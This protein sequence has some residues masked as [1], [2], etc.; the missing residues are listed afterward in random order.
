MNAVNAY[1]ERT[2]A[3]VLAEGIETDAHVS[4]ARSLGATLGQGWHF[5]RPSAAPVV[6]VAQPGG[7]GLRLP[8][9]TGRGELA[10]SVSP[11][12]CLPSDTVLMRAP[13]R[14]LVELSKQ[15][16]REAMRLGPTCVVAAT[17]QYREHFTA[18]TALRYRD[19]V[20]R[21]GFVCAIGR[22]L[23]VEPVPG[24]RGPSLGQD[25]P[26]LGEWDV[27]VLSPHFSTA[28]LARDLGDPGPDMDRTFEYALTYRR[29]TVTA[30]AHQLLLR[31][32]PRPQVTP[33]E[34]RPRRVGD[35]APDLPAGPAGGLAPLMVPTAPRAGFGWGE[36]LALLPELDLAGEALTKRALH[37]AR[38]GVT[39][40]DMTKPDEPL[41]FV[42][43]AFERLAGFSAVELLGRNCRLLQ[44]PDTD[45][46]AI[47]RIRSAVTDGRESREL[48]LNYRGPTREPW[49]NEVHLSPVTD[50]TGRVVQYIG[51]QS[52]VTARVEAE[53]ELVRERN[54]GRAY[55][56]QIEQ[57]AYTDPLTGLMNRRRFEDR[58]ELALLTA[59]M[60]E[61]A[62]ALLFMDLDDFKS[63]NDSHGHAAGDQLLQATARRLQARVRGADLL[64]RLGGDEFL[65]ALTGLHP[66][67]ATRQAQ[68][69][70][71]QLA[72]AV[73]VPVE[74]DTGQVQVTASTGIATSAGDAEEVG[75]LLHLADMRM[76]DL[77]HPALRE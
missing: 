14:L 10:E 73:S 26:V 50:Q 33:A 29:D 64:A 37:A 7:R 59:R 40:A 28:L 18:S 44:G 58:F 56:E 74:L 68:R 36:K 71:D 60:N 24:L 6:P 8:S 34:L 30:A 25:D 1:A 46:A 11:F 53:R 54:R 39:I 55:L 66:R 41:I 48:V 47:A 38:S 35:V 19:L 49:W 15:L 17:F 2:G 61:D 12:S 76:Y 67:T 3:L 75:R 77:K 9:A 4:R 62:V 32:A 52:D 31:V 42:N 43:A 57:L 70:A 72:A 20:E 5:G 27:V 63:V 23:P 21:T 69:I 22:G 45:R 16:E 13:K 51:V 65:V